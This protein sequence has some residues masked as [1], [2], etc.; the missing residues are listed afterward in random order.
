MK[1]RDLYEYAVL[2]LV[3]CSIAVIVS[4]HVALTVATVLAGYA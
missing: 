4:P 1:L 3:G 2:T